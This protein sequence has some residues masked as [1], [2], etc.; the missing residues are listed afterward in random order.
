M[1]EPLVSIIIPTFNRAHFLAQTI[2]SVRAQEYRNWECIVIDDG[3]TDG[4]SSLLQS[5]TS[6]DHRIIYRKRPEDLPKGANACRNY[7]FSISSGEF[8]NWFDSDDIMKPDFISKKLATFVDNTDGVISKRLVFTDDPG[9]IKSAEERTVL[10]KNLLGDFLTRKVSWYLQDVMWRRRFLIDKELF[11]ERLLAGQDRDFHSRM[12]LHE[13]QLAI[14]DHYLTLYR[15]HEDNITS[16]IKKEPA[17]R[18]SHMYGML[19]LVRL[20]DRDKKFTPDLRRY[21]F[22]TIIKY[23][24]FVYKNA[25]DMSALKELLSIVSFPDAKIFELRAKYFLALISFKLF[26]KGYFFLK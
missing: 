8:V 6:T 15:N 14:A 1:H 11:D 16:G 21:Y 25:K 26:G 7:G 17:L 24:P 3:S 18:V 10:T 13:P 9:K 19:K 5:Y 22:A 20:L 4:T 12:L 2:D 23:L